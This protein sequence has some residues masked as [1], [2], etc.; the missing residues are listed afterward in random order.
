[1]LDDVTV[2]PLSRD[3]VREPG[4]LANEWRELWKSRDL[5][6]NLVRRNL[7]T[8]HRGSFFGM[9]WSLATPILTVGLYTFIFTVILPTS[10]A[11]D[12]GNV[13]FAVYFFVGLATWNFFAT[14]VT[15]SAGSI[16]GSGYLLGKVYFRREVMP[17]SCVLSAGVT[18]LF[19]MGVA[20]V[21]TFIFVGLPDWQ[22]VF[23]P[24]IAIAIALL[25]YGL[26][27]IFATLTVFFRDIEHFIGILFQ[28][29]FWGTPI[30]YTLALVA[31]RPTFIDLLKANP[32]TGIVVSMRNIVLLDRQPDW[33]L[34]GYDF[35]VG[36]IA[37]VL[38]SWYFDR[39]QKLFPEMV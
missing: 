3:V 37:V 16:V 19:E 36:L 11:K 31:N 38:G 1:M 27:L 32:M 39:R 13:P 22:I 24:V 14:S 8:R 7:K 30:I 34:L 2:P 5:L 17:L 15:S 33:T 18:F 21:A 23:L 28:L 29:W 10:P 35:A 26:G 6:I 20:L 25:A 9:L 12:T 4:E